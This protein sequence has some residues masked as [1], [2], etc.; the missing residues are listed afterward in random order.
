[1]VAPSGSPSGLGQERRPAH[2]TEKK[3][4]D[5]KSDSGLKVESVVPGS[6]PGQRTRPRSR[7]RYPCGLGRKRKK[8]ESTWTGTPPCIR[9]GR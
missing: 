2:L 7:S 5:P 4:K 9:R 3:R 1:M 8:A 6:E